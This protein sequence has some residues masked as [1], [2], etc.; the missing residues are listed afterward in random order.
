MEII[1]ATR[2]GLQSKYICVLKVIPEGA[3]E[4]IV[5][6]TINVETRKVKV[7]FFTVVDHQ[8]LFAEKG[9]VRLTIDDLDSNS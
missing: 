5:E 6:D 4:A 1:A 3:D 7:L 8:L 2:I 9:R